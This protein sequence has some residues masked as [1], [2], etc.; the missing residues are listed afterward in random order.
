M[1]GLFLR[2]PGRLGSNSSFVFLPIL[3]GESKAAH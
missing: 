2:F 3:L 1:L